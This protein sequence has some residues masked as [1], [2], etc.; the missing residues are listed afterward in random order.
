MRK[1][2]EGI[3]ISGERITV[4]RAAHKERSRATQGVRMYHGEFDLSTVSGGGGHGCEVEGREEGRP[5]RRLIR[6][7]PVAVEQSG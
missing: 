7:C 5:P 6:L 2:A 3:R 1:E 4:G